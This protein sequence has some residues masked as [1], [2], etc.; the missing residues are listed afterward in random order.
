MTVGSCRSDHKR[1]VG[2]DQVLGG[3]DPLREGDRAKLASLVAL[4]ARHAQLQAGVVFHLTDVGDGGRVVERFAVLPADHGA[5]AGSVFALEV[6][7]LE[8]HF[9]AF[10]HEVGVASTVTFFAKYFGGKFCDVDGDV[11]ALKHDGEG[12]T[13]RL[14]SS[15]VLIILGRLHP[16]RSTAAKG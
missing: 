1:F 7:R 9:T 3:H 14:I 4:G 6:D 11:V 10:P 2:L 13:S 15:T 12:V 16:A 8:R 5:V